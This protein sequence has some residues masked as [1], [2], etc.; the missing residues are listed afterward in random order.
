MS[1]SDPDRWFG[2]SDEALIEYEERLYDEECE[3]GNTWEVRDEVL[4][5]MNRRGLCD[6]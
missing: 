6:A 1:M 5:E 3:G 2:W 4:W